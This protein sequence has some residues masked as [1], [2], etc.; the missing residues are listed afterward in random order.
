M[1]FFH[2]CLLLA[3][4]LLNALPSKAVLQ[5]DSLKTHSLFCAMS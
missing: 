2:T 1:K 5:E 3:L 4:L